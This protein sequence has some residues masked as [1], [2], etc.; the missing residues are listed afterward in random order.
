MSDH[1]LQ[2][3]IWVGAVLVVAVV[4]GAVWFLVNKLLDD[5]IGDEAFIPPREMRPGPRRFK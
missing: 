3:S 5:L 1:L 4:M 2:T